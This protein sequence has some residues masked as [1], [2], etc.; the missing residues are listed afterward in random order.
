MKEYKCHK[1]VHAYP[2]SRGDYN[3]YRCWLT[4]EDEN[5]KDEGYLVVYNRH[6]ET[7]YESWSPKAIFDDGYSEV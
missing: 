4:P 5:P 3:L 7:H 6:Q 1:K 2:M